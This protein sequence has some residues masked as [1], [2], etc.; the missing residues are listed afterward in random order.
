MMYI[1]M[2]TFYVSSE[3]FL[4]TFYAKN[5]EVYLA[6]FLLC[7]LQPRTSQVLQNCLQRLPSDSP[8]H[9]C[10]QQLGRGGSCHAGA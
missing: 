2:T 9:R 1:K 8:R 10:L 7:S 5:P 6:V 4:N 3:G